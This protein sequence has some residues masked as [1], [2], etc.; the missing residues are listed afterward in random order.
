MIL[1]FHAETPI[2]KGFNR[3]CIY[4]LPR[5]KYDFVP[6]EV[7]S[8]IIALENQDKSVVEGKLDEDE[9]SWLNSLIENEYC[10]YIP[11]AFI[12][13][14]PKIDFTW[15]NP[16]L[17]TNTIIDIEDTRIFFDFK[18]IENLNCKH[19]VIRFES[20]NSTDNIFTFLEE[21]LKEL[22]FKSVQVIL[23]RN[24]DIELKFYN[25]LKKKIL[26]EILLISNVTISKKEITKKTITFRPNF[27]IEPNTYCESQKHNLYFN[28][29]LY[30][31]NSGNFKN[32]VEC[33]T[34]VANIN[35][36]PL[37]ENVINSIS[38]Q[39]L[40]KINKDKIDVCK[41]CEFRY[42]CVDNR[43]P[44]KRKDG[45]YYF[46]QECSYNPYVSL[47]DTDEQFLS[48]EAVGVRSN[49]EGFAINETKVKTIN[50]S[51]WCD[52]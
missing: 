51:V 48:L 26:K 32:G 3:S 39:K 31:D 49:K 52:I 40:W 44:L 9:Q 23:K 46:D 11:E 43:I 30:I 35:K 37:I 18:A 36:E 25:L 14:F 50:E 42:M 12:D 15:K 20:S 24:F 6:N 21:K 29:K 33:T 10:F 38:F 19:L 5:R 22:T 4:D 17:I 16:S 47:W 41:D 1:K 28:R 13:C 45:T 7:L 2:V 34:I 8:K 27:I